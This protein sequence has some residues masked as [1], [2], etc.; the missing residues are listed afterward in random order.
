MRKSQIT[1]F[2]IMGIMLISAFALIFYMT[3]IRV[4][5]K[6]APAVEK[7]SEAISRD[8]AIKYYVISCLDSYTKKGLWLLANQSGFL[9]DDQAPIYSQNTLAFWSSTVGKHV[10]PFFLDGTLMTRYGI[11]APKLSDTSFLDKPA[12]FY[13][14]PGSLVPFP[15]STNA[16]GNLNP[17]DLRPSRLPPLCYSNGSNFYRFA[18]FGF[19]CDKNLYTPYAPL[20]VQYFLEQYIAN[21]TR[22]CVN[23]SMMSARGYNVTEAPGLNA[24]VMFGEDTV[25]VSLNFPL[26]INT[27]GQEPFTKVLTFTSEQPVRFKKIYELAYYMIKEDIR[28]I[29]FDFSNESA[30]LW[31][32]DLCPAFDEIS[33]SRDKYNTSCLYPGMSIIHYRDVCPYQVCGLWNYSDV[34]VIKDY[35][36]VLD[37]KPYFFAFAVENRIPALDNIDESVNSSYEYY[38]FV[39]TT[40]GLNLTRIYRNT[41]NPADD[42]YNIVVDVG[43]TIRLIPRAIDPDED[44]LTYKYSGWKTPVQIYNG[45]N[46]YVYWVKFSGGPE[47]PFYAYKTSGKQLPGSVDSRNY[48]EDSSW[49][50]TDGCKNDGNNLGKDANYPP[51]LSGGKLQP[52]DV[53]YHWVRVDVTDNAGLS[54]WQDIKIQVRCKPDGNKCCDEGA[55]YHIRPSTSTCGICMTCNSEGAC[56][57]DNTKNDDCP[58]CQKCSKNL[59]SGKGECVPETGTNTNQKCGAGSADYECCL[60]NCLKRADT[61]PPW[62]LYRQS[63]WECY[64]TD[65][66]CKPNAQNWE[67]PVSHNGDF[68]AARAGHCYNGYCRDSLNQCYAGSEKGADCGTV[69]SSVATCP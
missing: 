33:Q 11:Y 63:C 49:F 22:S 21:K 43:D 46:E 61:A 15:S 6:T 50:S 17:A 31:L 2:M 24:T 3:K 54:D 34:V 20:S 25:A 29:F 45:S 53:G 62:I 16:F 59:V 12:P 69:P 52:E 23:L 5:S 51:L 67:Y 39:N 19:S 55:D 18:G 56:V 57:Y 7:I 13:P 41:S 60:G 48:W 38:W 65:G 8:T 32:V 9:Y 36:S 58:K 14:Y 1:M 68:C 40:C 66:Q 44:K 28:N 42:N 64:N 37:T 10:V 30:A 47:L 26:L 4:E 35:A 27:R